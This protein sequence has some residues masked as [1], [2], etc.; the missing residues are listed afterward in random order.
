MKLLLAVLLLSFWPTSTRPGSDL[1]D[2]SATKPEVSEKQVPTKRQVQEAKIESKDANIDVL[3]NNN[4]A[5]L[6][7]FTDAANLESIR[8]HGLLS[9]SCL[10]RLSL[11]AVMN[12][13]EKSRI[14]D[15]QMGLEKFVRLSFNE[16]NPMKYVAKNE[17]RISRPVML[18]IKLEVVS[19]Q[20]V[21]FFDC[22]AT[23]HDAVQSSSPSVVHFDIVKAANQFR[24]ATELQRFYQAEVLVPSPVPPE[25]IVFPDDVAP[26]VSAKSK[27]KLPKS[28]STV[29]C[30]AR[31]S[32]ST[33]STSEFSCFIR[34]RG[35]GNLENFAKVMCSLF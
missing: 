30:K 6:Y 7:H 21:L 20:G 22:N 1:V 28:A 10:S 19:K 12:S 8:K 25:L 16:Q 31:R 5:V 2:I 11:D 34:R 14:I 32:M 4:I 9:A 15:K 35:G 29:L 27:P 24:V 3:R 17:G 18:Q 23:R 26:K 33:S 13:D